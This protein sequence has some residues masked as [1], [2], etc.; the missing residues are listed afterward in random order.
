MKLLSRQLGT[1]YSIELTVVEHECIR[2]EV[3]EVESGVIGH[4]V[5]DQVTVLSL[6]HLLKEMVEDIKRTTVLSLT[7][8]LEEAVKDIRRK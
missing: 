4:A 3:S 5:L 2:L 1:E 6:A 8:L 7:R